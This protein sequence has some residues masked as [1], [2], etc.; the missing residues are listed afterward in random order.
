[1]KTLIAI[2]VVFVILCG[3]WVDAAKGAEMPGMTCKVVST[4]IRDGKKPGTT[5]IVTKK[6]CTKESK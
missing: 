4:L 6:V 5:E 1:M 3:L 2:P